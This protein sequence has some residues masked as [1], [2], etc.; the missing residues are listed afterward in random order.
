VAALEAK[1]QGYDV[2]HAHGSAR[3]VDI[4]RVPTK[5][6][7]KE[8]QAI[9]ARLQKL[10]ED[11]KPHKTSKNIFSYN[12]HTLFNNELGLARFRAC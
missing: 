3:N 7:T 1:Q 4:D 8:D 11:T 5:G 2:T 10:K 6:L 12:S 9:A